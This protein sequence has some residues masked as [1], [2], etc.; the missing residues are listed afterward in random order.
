MFVVNNFERFH[1]NE[2]R[3]TAIVCSNWKDLFRKEKKTQ[4][5]MK[6]KNSR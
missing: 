4:R 3:N 1:Q 5:L 6:N 2:N